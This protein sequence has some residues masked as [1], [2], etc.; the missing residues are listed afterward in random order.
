MLSVVIPAY[1]EENRLPKTLTAVH[2]HLKGSRY[3]IIVVD[4]GST[5]NT[6]KVIGKETLISLPTNQGK[7]E[8]IK[9][10][11][12][13]AKGKRILVM[14]ADLAVPMLELNKLLNTRA[15]IAIGSRALPDSVIHG[16]VKL[17]SL[18]GK[19][20]PIIVRTITGM[21]YRDTQCG[22]K[23]F[24]HRA[25]KLIFSNVQTK[26]FAFDVEV[27]LLAEMMGFQPVEVAIEW[28]EI[29]GSKVKLVQDS[30]RMLRE[31]DHLVTYYKENPIKERREKLAHS[32]HYLC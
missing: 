13:A 3:E 5:D 31:L 17:R 28:Y 30:L 4:D 12:L 23:L 6:K 11:V 29:P 8:A 16:R 18:A 7:G 14:D 25:A 22:F 32:S 24:S 1:N 26:G 15:E 21:K 9:T 10:G 19:V 20:F 2:S 27:L